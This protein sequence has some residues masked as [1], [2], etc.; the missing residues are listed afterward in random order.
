MA[1]TEAQKKVIDS[2]NESLL[3]SAAAG[4]GKTSVLVERVTQLLR[5]GAELS[6]LLIVT[7][8]N[9]AA[10]EMKERI[11]NT[12]GSSYVRHSHICTF[13]KFAIDV[14][15]QYYHII[16]INPA[17]QICDEYNQS[18][19]KSEALDEMFEELFEA[20]DPDFI[21]FLNCYCSPKSNQNAKEMILAFH[22]F[23]E[24]L[25]NP[26]VYAE[27]IKNGSAFDDEKYL[28]FFKAIVQNSLSNS[29]SALDRAKNMLLHPENE[30]DET[31]VDAVTPCPKLAEK[32]ATDYEELKAIYDKIESD[33]VEYIKLLSEYSFMRMAATN[34]EKPTYNLIKGKF[35]FIRD[36]ATSAVKKMK[37]DYSS[38]SIEGF[39]AEKQAMEKPLSTLV[40]LTNNFTDRYQAK[41]RASNLLDFSDIEHFALKILEDE[42]VCK[43]LRESFDYIFVDEYQDSNLVQDELISRISRKDNVFMVG[44]VKQSIYK[45]R[46]AEPELFLS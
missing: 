18:I 5:E 6:R 38:F 33:G 34:P 15:Q 3:V 8:T 28:S 40:S 2:R 25:P 23:L 9:A 37:A 30:V 43:E 21:D 45:F 10:G 29:L 1:W 27:A 32:V 39:M 7:F 36:I 26:E 16:G 22:N 13:H 19:F 11:A 41:K 35:A 20:E 12:L 46:L 24:S 17:V 44:D 31:L 14:I 42:N 4:S